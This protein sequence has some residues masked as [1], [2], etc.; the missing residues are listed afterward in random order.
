VS[1]TPFTVRRW[2]RYGHDRLYVTR[3]DGTKVGW[4]SL[5]TGDL[6]VADDSD[7]VAVL[8]ALRDEEAARP[9]LAELSPPKSPAPMAG[10]P[11]TDLAANRP[12]AAARA[13]ADRELEEMRGRSR[14]ATAVARVFDLHT[15]ERAWR[16]GAE[17]EE[18]VGPRLE[19]LVKDGWH[20]L[21][22]VPV[23]NNDADID[24]LLLDQHSDR[25]GA[26]DHERTSPNEGTRASQFVSHARRHRH[27]AQQNHRIALGI[28]TVSSRGPGHGRH[29]R[30]LQRGRR[31][32]RTRA[33]TE[34]PRNS[35]HPQLR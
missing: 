11:I 15:D 34:V 10:E 33:A 9:W 35:A 29:T 6:K 31:R 18:V 16:K 5:T 23:G 1:L 8:T 4:L 26:G 17:G 25:A 20:V 2:R 7:R 30:R 13:R 3:L 19:R 21:H 12:G 22:A 32:L 28:L 27:A 14:I 24:H